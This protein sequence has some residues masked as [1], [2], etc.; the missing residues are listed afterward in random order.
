M[1]SIFSRFAVRPVRLTV[2]LL[3]AAGALAACGP[4]IS[5]FNE[6]AYEQATSL[7]VESLALMEAATEPYAD[8]AEDVR[9]LQV[10]LKKAHE[11]A[12]NRPHNAISTEQW[13]TLIDPEGDLLG[14]FL[15]RWKRDSTLNETYVT[16][17]V[18]QVRAAFNTIIKLESGKIKP[19]DVRGEQ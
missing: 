12:K 15:Q 19:E 18:K 6:T 3:F 16:E 14:G 2:A 17:K 4:T 7:K 11:Y 9:A 5:K 10:E 8:H 13:D 1:R